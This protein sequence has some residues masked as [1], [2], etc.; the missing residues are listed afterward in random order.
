MKYRCP[1]CRH[2]LEK[3]LD[4]KCPYCGRFMTIKNALRDKA[5]AAA[6]G[7]KHRAR[8][9]SIE[10]IKRDY[11]QK[12]SE[13]HGQLPPSLFRS[14]TFY[15][16]VMVV[17]ALVGV[18]LF[19]AADK[20]VENKK[21]SLHQ[22]AMQ[23]VDV[24]AEALGRYHFHAGVYPSDEQGLAALVRDPDVAKWNGPYINLLRKD[25]WNTEFIYEVN[26]GGVPTVFSCGPD[27]QRGTADDIMPDPECFNPGTEWTNGWVSAAERL[28]GVIILS[29]DPTSSKSEE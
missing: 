19:S 24:L 5:T 8:H 6:A 21:K 29:E 16:G 28:P 15:L 13:L 2:E 7:E 1:Y 17:F 25:P 12:K 22:R 3:L 4:P 26:Q 20:S 23:H 27:K 9:R 11:E 14:P 18:L 10:R